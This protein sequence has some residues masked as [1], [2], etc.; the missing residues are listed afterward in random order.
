M[1]N[2]IKNSIYVL[3]TRL[4]NIFQPVFSNDYYPFSYLYNPDYIKAELAPPK[5]VLI[6]RN[7]N[8]I[9]LKLPPFNPIIDNMVALEDPNKKIIKS[10]ALYGKISKNGVNV[11]DTCKDLQNTGVRQKVG[12]VV[13][14]G[15]FTVPWILIN[16]IKKKQKLDRQ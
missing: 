3:S 8:S 9:T 10:M 7:S 2:A 4:E 1:S 5:P 13:S 14:V 12:A 6:S 11:S 15:K 16:H